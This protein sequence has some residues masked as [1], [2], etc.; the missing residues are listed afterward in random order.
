VLSK[1][2]WRKIDIH[3][4]TLSRMGFNF[5]ILSTVV[6]RPCF[7]RV[8][9]MKSILKTIPA[10]MLKSNKVEDTFVIKSY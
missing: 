9:A 1:V 2:C 10:T 5:Y 6:G 8:I 7:N 3:G 4:L